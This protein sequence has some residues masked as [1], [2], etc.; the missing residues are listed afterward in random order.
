M[1][2]IVVAKSIKDPA[3]RYRV[4][5]IVQRLRARGDI[6]IVFYE[7]GF[8]SQL[9]LIFMAA[10]SD[11]L[12]IQRKLMNSVIVWI[13]GRFSSHIVFDYDDAIF[14]KSTGQVSSTRSAR[15]KAIV[16]A[17]QLVLAGNKYLS[18]AAAAEGAQVA[19]VP[20]SVDLR[21]YVNVKKYEELMLVW[22]GSSSTA[23]YLEQEKEMLSALAR[24]IPSVKLRVVGDFQFNVSGL[25]VECVTWSE[26]TESQMLA[27]S[28]IG[29][30]PMWDDPWSRG[31]CSLKVIQYMAA[32]LPV[33]TS[34]VGSNE[35]VVIDGVTGFLVETLED[36]CAAI[37]KL[38]ASANLRFEM[39]SAGRKVVEKRYNQET[40]A[41]MV[42]SLLD[43]VAAKKISTV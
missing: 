22:I 19:N 23:R 34:K 29:I 20:T 7:P 41:A 33:V 26:A 35:S 5:P 4:H 13:L 38:G 40:T 3:T 28:H 9:R 14:V 10:T 1:K 24:R 8:V 17:S 36:W 42:V 18:Q 6:V 12:F 32:G 43:D 11:L 37:E 16:R 39:G 21:R 2:F 15:Y 25:D 30:A 31:K 27:S